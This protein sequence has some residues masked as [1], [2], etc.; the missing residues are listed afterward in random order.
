MTKP[1]LS[2]LQRAITWLRAV[3]ANGSLPVR[4]LE[5]LAREVGITRRTLRRARGKLRVRSRPDG[6]GGPRVLSLPVGTASVDLS[7]DHRSVSGDHPV[8]SG[9]RGQVVT[10]AAPVERERRQR[11]DSSG[12]RRVVLRRLR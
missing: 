3:L 1:S 11:L 12:V 6:F 4:E 7:D 10:H 2:A 8:V 9:D 5:S